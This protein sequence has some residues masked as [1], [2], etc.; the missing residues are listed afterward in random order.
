MYS[1]HTLPPNFFTNLQFRL[2]LQRPSFSYSCSTIILFAF[3]IS[4]MPSTCPI[5][6]MSS[7]I[8]TCRPR[9]LKWLLFFTVSDENFVFLISS[10]HSTCP[11]HLRFVAPNYVYSMKNKNYDTP[12]FAVFIIILS[13]S[14]S[15]LVPHD[16][17]GTLK[18]NTIIAIPRSS[19]KAENQVLTSLPFH[20]L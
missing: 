4:S 12:H 2:N 20:V 14:F 13:T 6:I 10:M 1:V 9:P 16:L 8:L 3:L 17:Q 19:V 15:L 7:R 18:S 5:L 11:T